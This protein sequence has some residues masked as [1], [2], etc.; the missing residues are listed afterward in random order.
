MMIEM[1]EWVIDTALTQISQWQT[2]GLT[3][4]VSISV[5]IAAI[6]LQQP[7]FTNR[8]IR[9]LDAH[10]DVE[11]HNFEL[12]VLE[13]TAIDDIQHVSTIMK[14]C[15]A[16][17]VKFALDDFGTGYSSLTYL[18]RLPASLIKID[19]IFVRDM[20]INADDLAIVEGVIALAKS[21]KREVIAEGVET[22][23]HG[24]IL[25]LLGCDLAQGY[26]IARPMPANN[27]PTWINDW[28]PDVS[29]QI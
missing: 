24:R 10:P 29:W 8:L 4:P 5:N 11:P 7:D 16:L 12:E 17:G 3:L 25:L 19:Q 1:G 14:S 15:S 13:T 27:I 23:E 2:M 28:K 6:H 20:L 26:G 9:L 18:R 22:V 21:F